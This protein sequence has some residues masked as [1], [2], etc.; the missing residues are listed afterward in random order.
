[1]SSQPSVVIVP[2]SFCPTSMYDPLVM[3]LRAKGYDI[4]VLEPPCYPAGYKANSVTQP[5]MYDD[6]AYVNEFMRKLA[7]G[8]KEV[9]LLAHSYGGCPAT[10]GIKDVTK[11]EREHQGRTGG[12]VRLAYLTAAVPR[13][14]ESCGQALAREESAPIE[15]DANGWVTQSDPAATASLCFNNLTLEDGISYVAKFGKHHG[16]C[17]G[18]VLTHAGYKDV[19]VSWFFAEEDLVVVPKVQQ[20]AIDVIEGS[21][22]GT[23]RD[24][25][26]VDVTK[27]ACDHFPL[28]LD[29]KREQVSVWIEGLVE[30]GGRE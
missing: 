7:D 19:P 16:A 13:V 12:V 27:V 10:E 21:W 14:G 1:M 4:H 2:G 29:E 6:A 26:K 5:S 17:F 24:G 18:D 25:M 11:K 9:I 20:T 8:G 3:P 23:E 22:V 15:V 30:K 28:V